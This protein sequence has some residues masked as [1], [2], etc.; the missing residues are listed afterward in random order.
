LCEA[1][2][3]TFW[4]GGD[5]GLV[6]AG[7]EV[8]GAVRVRNIGRM[9]S[10]YTDRLST[11]TRR[12]SR[13]ATGKK[14]SGGGCAG[15]SCSLA[16]GAKAPASKIEQAKVQAPPLRNSQQPPQ[17]VPVGVPVSPMMQN[18]R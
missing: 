11:L 5:V 10:K 3:V 8:R 4:R 17:H 16:G 18:G 2:E 12:R 6:E 7:G 13:K 14:G 15:G 1:D 9:R